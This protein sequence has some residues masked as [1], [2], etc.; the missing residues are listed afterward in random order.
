[1]WNIFKDNHKD[2]KTFFP[3]LTLNM[4]LFVGYLPSFLLSGWFSLSWSFS[5][6]PWF[7]EKLKFGVYTSE[8][9]HLQNQNRWCYCISNTLPGEK[10]QCE[11]NNISFPTKYKFSYSYKKV[12]VNKKLLFD[13]FSFFVFLPLFL[14]F[15]FCLSLCQLSNNF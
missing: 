5:L 1:M 6:S 15:Y 12:K 4:Y 13:F 8:V 14:M 2:T 3:L 10:R 11:W 9:W 7:A